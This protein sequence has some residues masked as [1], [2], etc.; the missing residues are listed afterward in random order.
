MNDLLIPLALG[1]LAA[2]RWLCRREARHRHLCGGPDG[3]VKG[4][5]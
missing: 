3:S 2:D 5:A 1:H 4:G